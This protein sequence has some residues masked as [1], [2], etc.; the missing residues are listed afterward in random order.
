MSSWV[1]LNHPVFWFTSLAASELFCLFVSTLVNIFVNKL[2]AWKN[3]NQIFTVKSFAQPIL[4]YHF[5]S[6]FHSLH[7]VF[8]KVANLF[9]W[10]IYFCA[11]FIFFNDKGSR[12]IVNSLVGFSF[13]SFNKNSWFA[14]NFFLNEETFA[15]STLQSKFNRNRLLLTV[16]WMCWAQ[17]E[18]RRL[19]SN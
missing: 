14:P 2:T 11:C 8:V 9:G 13:R 15:M 19:I 16:S 1:K 17:A 6:R 18:L 4:F 10:T 5:S 7:L 3:S 12:T